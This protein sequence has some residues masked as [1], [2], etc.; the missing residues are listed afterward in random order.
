MQNSKTTINTARTLGLT[1][2]AI[3]IYCSFDLWWSFTSGLIDQIIAAAIGSGSVAAQYLFFTKRKESKAYYAA[4]CILLVIS[5]IATM[6]WLESRFN[7]TSDTEL[8]SSASYNLK[9]LKLQQLNDTLSLQNASAKKDLANQEANYT[10]RANKTLAAAAITQAAINEEEASLKQLT[11]QQ[12]S[13]KKSG[14]AIANILGH[15][16]WALWLF[17][18]I[19]VDL[20]AVL[21]FAIVKNELEKNAARPLYP[22]P[23][24]MKKAVLAATPSVVIKPFKTLSENDALTATIANKII[25]NIY[26]D[27]PSQQAVMND[28]KIRHDRAKAI[29]KE[30][31]QMQIVEWTGT[32]FKRLNNEFTQQ[33][34]ELSA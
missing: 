34:Q 14:S 28:H 22:T 9:A 3:S 13:S 5:T 27:M 1:F 29:F 10:G 8:K 17:L 20:I 12:P 33:K 7:S 21:C 2:A 15:G 26:G 23:R 25:S 6:G 11:D 16:R 19:M 18:A 31:Q 24:E 32:R 4:A 30:L